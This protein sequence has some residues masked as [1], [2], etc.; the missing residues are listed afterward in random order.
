MRFFF[1]LSLSLLV[2]N[3]AV[4][5][6]DSILPFEPE[7]KKTKEEKGGED[8]VDYLGCIL[9]PPPSFSLSLSRSR[10]AINPLDRIS[11]ISARRRGETRK[12]A[13]E[14]E[15]EDDDDGKKKMAPQ[16]H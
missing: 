1:S 14:E 10:R 13:R 11:I 2:P 12:R 9:L 6:L 4:V 3:G 7:K 15:E 16:R 8:H 5:K